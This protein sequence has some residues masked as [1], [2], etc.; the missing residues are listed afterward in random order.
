MEQQ[1]SEASCKGLLLV[2]SGPSGTG[3][4]TVIKTLGSINRSLRRSVSATTRKP[5]ANEKEGVHY[6]FKSED[7]FKEMIKNNEILEW[8]I[9]CGNYYGTPVSYVDACIKEKSDI[10][11]E[12]TVKG[13]EHIKERY[14]E[15]ILIFLL[16]P[17]MDELKRR[18]TGRGTESAEIINRRINE[19][20][21]EI[22]HIGNFDYV[23]I[24]DEIEKA[25]DK[26]NIV[27][28]AEKMRV[29]RNKQVITEIFN[30]G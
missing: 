9:F 29:S 21:E 17:S 14:P 23:I 27:I 16:P 28:S 22:G 24:N 13:A 1:K 8:D 6:F 3:K 19:A 12:I 15:S 10:L 25:V 2:I 11:F 26:I 30:G 7:E 5:R 18:I 4:S 20:S